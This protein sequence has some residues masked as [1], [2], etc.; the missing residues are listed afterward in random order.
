[1]KPNSNNIEIFHLQS[2]PGIGYHH[3]KGQKSETTS[4]I[5]P[6]PKHRICMIK[7]FMI[8]S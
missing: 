2:D 6:I 7:M 3:N 5:I 4:K 1:M 8:F